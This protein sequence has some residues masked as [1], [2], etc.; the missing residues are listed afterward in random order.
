M[1][2]NF[3][4]QWLGKKIDYDHVYGYQCV[5]LILQ[6][7]YEDYGI[8]SGVSGNAI[9]YWTKPSAPL[10]AKF[11]KIA[12][13]DAQAGDIVVLNGL[14][15]NPYGHIGIATGNVNATEIEILEQNGADGNGSGVGGDAIRTR[16]IEKVRVAGLL[17][18]KVNEAAAA[19]PSAPAAP[20]ST[21]NELVL[22]STISEWHVYHP[23]GPYNL[24]A[25]IGVLDPQKFGGLIYDILGSPVA[26]FYLIQ[27][28][29]FGEVAIYAGPDT[30]AVIRAKIATPAPAPAAPANPTPVQP[31][32]IT[33]INEDVK[34]TDTLR[35]R[36]GPSTQDSQVAVDGE[37][38]G[39]LHTN[40]I[41][42]ITG[43][44]HGED[45]TGNDIWLRS[46]KGNWMWS[47]GTNFSV[48]QTTTVP[49]V[50]APAVVAPAA[51]VVPP[52]VAAVTTT[53]STSGSSTTSV[54]V[55]V[56]KTPAPTTFVKAAGLFQTTKATQA[57]DLTGVK[58][59]IAIAKNWIV[60]RVEVTA[61]GKFARDKSAFEKD[62]QYVIP[63]S[64]L[65]AVGGKNLDGIIQAAK[66]VAKD[67]EDVWDEIL[68]DL[69]MDD[70]GAR[71]AKKQTSKI[72]TEVESDVKSSGILGLFNRKKGK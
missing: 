65:K 19:A 42:T 59:P 56:N 53:T 35:V 28:A 30:P 72:V 43:Y 40:D 51:P 47:G 3:I 10:L 15:G 31:T 8:G 48:G 29:D 68:A 41:V 25:A 46:V 39:D 7:L 12:S 27:T 36:S 69:T 62:L 50:A 67:T 33:T 26:N 1:L 64:A 63:M 24:A 58:S 18:P 52:V 16:F 60:Q 6:Y 2:Q 70:S 9:D 22:P 17:R 71:T 32:D 37:P 57:I 34:I 61:D 13:T 49:E 23:G 55:T 54:N 38:D 11:D 14:A 20:A 44:C 4:N 5:D 21:G 45:V 66:T